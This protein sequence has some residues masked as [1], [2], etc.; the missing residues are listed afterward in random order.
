MQP[1]NNDLH[2][3]NINLCLIHYFLEFKDHNAYNVYS[4]CHITKIAHYLYSQNTN[5][6]FIHYSLEFTDY[7]FFIRNLKHMT[8]ENACVYNAHV[9]Y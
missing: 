6:C 4:V 8:C 1:Q 9:F 2:S 7:N 5:S 3:Q